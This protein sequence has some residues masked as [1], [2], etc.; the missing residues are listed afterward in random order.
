MQQQQQKRPRIRWFEVDHEQVLREKA[1][2]I[3]SH[4]RVFGAAAVVQRSNDVDD[5]G[6]VYELRQPSQ[7]QQHDPSQHQSQPPQP[8]CWPPGT[9][10][11]WVAHDLQRDPET[12]V[13]HKLLGAAVGLDPQLP[14]LVVFECVQMYLPPQAV[15]ALLSSLAAALSDCHVCSYEPILG[16]T[17]R[18]DA[19]GRM[20]EGNL[21]KAGV[22]QRDS[23]LV[24][25]RT[26]RAYLDHF[27][28]A[29]FGRAAVGCDMHTAYETVLTAAE[30]QKAN[31]CEFL[32]E[33]EEWVLIMRHYC[34]VVASNNG[35][36]AVG[37]KFCA[38]GS[39]SPVGFVKG[40][41]E[42]LP[43]SDA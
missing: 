15:E 3:N 18:D 2:T 33:L 6:L 37:R 26:L 5:D 30:R 9:S 20:M 32:D 36:S 27:C 16:R 13:R 43:Q 21:T 7:Q 25:T 40:R 35:Q 38:V 17:D 19:F 41:C 10:C 14:T 12:L 39:D 28:Q 1:A 4:P 34:L 31:R 29:G 22:A 8:P 11:H 42:V 24:Q 23:C